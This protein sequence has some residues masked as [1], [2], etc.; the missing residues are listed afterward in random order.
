LCS[1]ADSDI[2][3]GVF[4]PTWSKAQSAIDPI[5]EPGREWLG[6]R[7]ALRA[8]GKEESDTG[9]KGVRL[10]ELTAE[11]QVYVQSLDSGDGDAA[12]DVE[13]DHRPGIYRLLGR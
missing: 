8:L 10:A 2:L 12:V 11:L 9:P 4:S 3:W 1:T 7:T 6:L 5:Y 13:G